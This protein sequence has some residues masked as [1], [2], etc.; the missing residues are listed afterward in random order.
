MLIYNQ[1]VWNQAFKG[2]VKKAEPCKWDI[3]LVSRIL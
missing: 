1:I 3:P 2:I